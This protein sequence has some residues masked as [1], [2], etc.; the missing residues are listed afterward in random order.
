MTE[1]QLHGSVLRP[2]SALRQQSEISTVRVQG[3]RL[4]AQRLQAQNPFYYPSCYAA[5]FCTVE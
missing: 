4:Q 1:A 2:E 5:R 3:Q